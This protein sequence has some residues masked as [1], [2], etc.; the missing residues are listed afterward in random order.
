MIAGGA[1]YAIV[2]ILSAISESDNKKKDTYTQLQSE[3]DIAVFAVCDIGK[4]T[5]I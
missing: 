2:S 4:D 5:E 3:T 1:Y